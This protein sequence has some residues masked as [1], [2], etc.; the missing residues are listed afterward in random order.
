ML[1]LARVHA[2]TYLINSEMRC[3]RRVLN[4]P[5]DEMR[6]AG[7]RDITIFMRLLAAAVSFS[8]L[9]KH[10]IFISFFLKAIGLPSSDYE[11]WQVEEWMRR[12]KTDRWNWQGE[13]SKLSKRL[14]TTLLALTHSLTHP[15]TYLFTDVYADIDILITHICIC[16]CIYI[17]ICELRMS[18]SA[19]VYIYIYI[20]IT[21]KY[22]NLQGVTW[23]VSLER[24]IFYAYP[25]LHS[26]TYHDGITHINRLITLGLSLLNL[27]YIE[28][29][30]QSC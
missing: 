14:V 24:K 15:R 25:A 27:S 18:I 23:N 5:R 1:A 30:S 6:H 9:S 20:Y 12:G 17:Y 2:F 29:C 19:C 28:F 7:D 11:D 16:V 13:Q 3:L 21:L 10:F 4:M 22:T 26:Y 8:C